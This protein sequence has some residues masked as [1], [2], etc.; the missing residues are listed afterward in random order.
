MIRECVVLAAVNFGWCAGEAQSAR[1]ASNTVT[2]RKDPVVVSLAREANVTISWSDSSGNG[3]LD[4]D[5]SGLVLIRIANFTGDPLYRVQAYV[6]VAG[7]QL[8]LTISQ[9]E[10]QEVLTQG[11]VH[12][13]QVGLRATQECH[14]GTVVLQVECSTTSAIPLKYPGGKIL[15]IDL[16]GTS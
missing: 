11:A 9:A 4:A 10:P 13:F 16:R 6:T 3:Y 5:E 2:F 12:E 15:E 14:T 1:G 7:E 8:G